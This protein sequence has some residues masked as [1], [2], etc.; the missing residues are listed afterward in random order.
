MDGEAVPALQAC[1]QQL[2]AATSFEEAKAVAVR[3]MELRKTASNQTEE[4]RALVDDLA[5]QAIRRAEE[6]KVAAPELETE[7]E[8]EPEVQLGLP[9]TMDAPRP[10]AFAEAALQTGASYE[11]AGDWARAKELYK[12]TA[13]KLLALRASVS[14][15]IEQQAIGQLMSHC[16]QRL[17]QL[18]QQPAPTATTA[19]PHPQSVAGK[20]DAEL[21]A[22]LDAM[23]RSMPTAPTEQDL[24]ARF[25]KLAGRP[26]VSAGGAEPE[27]GPAPP[28]RMSAAEADRYEHE[29]L[30]ELG[31]PAS[32]GGTEV[33]RLLA[34]AV[35]SNKLAHRYGERIEGLDDD[36][37]P[38]GPGGEHSAVA[39]LMQQAHDAA[40]L[41]Q[42]Y[43]AADASTPTVAGDEAAGPGSA[44][45]AGGEHAHSS[46]DEDDDVDASVKRWLRSLGLGQHTDAIAA[47]AHDMAEVA[48]ITKEQAMMLPMTAS[49][50]ERLL[51]AIARL[52]TPD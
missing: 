26:A 4:F 25:A 11:R 42:K 47:F 38:D 27:R 35:T 30:S 29:K 45:Q 19:P 7:P 46:D 50:R 15:A 52:P 48:W 37:D 44:A 43:G 8:P 17:E 23:K 13:Q 22:R 41:E 32:G 10:Y 1:L 39:L 28:P 2:K 18:S 12:D 16:I 24:H 40:R 51:V 20:S 5:T 9:P 31:L 34:E 49:E 14:D 36:D 21:R 6:L 3:T 33:E